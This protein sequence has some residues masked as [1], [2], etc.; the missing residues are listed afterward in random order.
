MKRFKLWNPLKL[1]S[2]ANE[3][4]TIDQ[5]EARS[6]YSLSSHIEVRDQLGLEM[7]L[8]AIHNETDTQLAYREITA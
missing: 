4:E 5:Y 7:V 3:G 1:S 6:G 2:Y 8:E